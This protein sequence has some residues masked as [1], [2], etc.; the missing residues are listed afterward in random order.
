MA[1]KA[2]EDNPTSEIARALLPVVRVLNQVRAH[3]EFCRKAGV[4]IDRAGAAVL[5]K[6]HVEGENAR[7]TDLAERLGIDP[8]A[9][10]R[11]VQQLE[12]DGLLCRSVDPR[13]ARAC[14]LKLTR[15][16]RTCIERLLRARDEWLAELLV[17]WSRSDQKELARLLQL[18][19]STIEHDLEARN[20][21]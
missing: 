9:V 7:L 8:P 5:Y 12:R 14:R 21:H 18:F 3:E 10:T 2:V 20:G 4:G 16:G 6:L 19:A 15:Q 13:D 17:G 1:L 11:K